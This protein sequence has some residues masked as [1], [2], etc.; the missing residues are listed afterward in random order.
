MQVLAIDRH[1]EGEV[2]VFLW[3]GHDALPVPHG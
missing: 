2:V 3:D 1:H